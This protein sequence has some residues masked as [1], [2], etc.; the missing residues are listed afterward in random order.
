M[1]ILPRETVCKMYAERGLIYAFVNIQHTDL[2][3]NPKN[4]NAQI[5]TQYLNGERTAC[6]TS[7]TYPL[8]PVIVNELRKPIAV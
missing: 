5:L 2:L 1:F 6:G 4:R 8:C 3:I 7:L